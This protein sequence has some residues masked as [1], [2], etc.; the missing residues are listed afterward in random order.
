[1]FPPDDETPDDWSDE[2]WDPS[3]DEAEEE[4]GS[5][6]PTWRRPLL[7]AVAA[8]TAVALVIVPVYN[9]L[10]DQAADKGLEVCGFDYCIV[11][12]AM[13]DAGLELEMSSLYNTILGD[14]EA[15]SLARQL[16]DDLGVD[17][18]GLVV[19]DDLD[20]RVGG[21]YDPETRSIAIERPARAWTVLHEVAHVI[22]S[23]HAGDFQGVLIELV[24]V[25]RPEA[26]GG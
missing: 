4:T 5:Q 26:D 8:F 25:V 10:V 6:V 12:D 1:M 13:R 23:G 7:I 21:L 22:E 16:T 24:R 19:V 15:S 3:W 9:L 18:V 14:E 20:G 17:P 11:E 2:G